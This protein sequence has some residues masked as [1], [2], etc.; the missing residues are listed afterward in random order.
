MVG[1]I[2]MASFCMDCEHYKVGGYC[3][4]KHKAVCAIASDCDRLRP[5]KIRIAPP[6]AKTKLCSKCR[7]ILPEESFARCSKAKDGRQAYCKECYKKM[8]HSW[9]ERHPNA[10]KN[11]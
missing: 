5:P 7:Q 9:R 6:P 3:S 1:G 11:G 10:K 8:W 2:T 4:L